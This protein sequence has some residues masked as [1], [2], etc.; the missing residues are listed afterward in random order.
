[1]KKWFLFFT[2]LSQFNLSVRAEIFSICVTQ[3]DDNSELFQLLV[4]TDDDNK[5]IHLIQRRFLNEDDFLM[6]RVNLTRVFNRTQLESGVILYE[7]L[8][9]EVIR[10]QVENL[11]LSTGGTARMYYK[12]NVLFQNS[13][14]KKRSNLFNIKEANGS[15]YA[16]DS[17]EDRFNYAFINAGRTGLK[18]IIFS[19]NPEFDL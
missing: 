8:G 9:Y 4:E 14:S 12:T 2:L 3:N 10:L 15:W 6:N 5:L 1:M 11:N 7:K 13:W 17:N 18:N 16:T 19:Y